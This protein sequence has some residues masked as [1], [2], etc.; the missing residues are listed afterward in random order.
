MASRK[1]GTG[2]TAT[3][4]GSAGGAVGKGKGK[5]GSGDSAVKQVQINTYC[6]NIKEFTAQNLGKLF[7]AQALQEYNN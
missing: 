1:E 2:S 4:S 7:M 6:Q 3:S 5:G